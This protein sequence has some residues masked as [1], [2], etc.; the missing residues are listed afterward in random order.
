MKGTGDSRLKDIT[1][2]VDPPQTL[3][4]EENG[5]LASL[6]YNYDLARL[7]LAGLLFLSISSLAVLVLLIYKSGPNGEPLVGGADVRWIFAP[8]CLVFA[9]F[10]AYIFN[11]S[12]NMSLNLGKGGKA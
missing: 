2:V 8:L 12:L 3:T 6:R 7:S 11:R 1:K 5:I 4:P 10:G 9:L